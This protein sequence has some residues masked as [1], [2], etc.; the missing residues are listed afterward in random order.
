MGITKRLRGARLACE[1][2]GALVGFRRCR[3][4]RMRVSCCDREKALLSREGEILRRR[5]ISVFKGNASDVLMA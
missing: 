3:I 2:L 1:L 5:R 4:D